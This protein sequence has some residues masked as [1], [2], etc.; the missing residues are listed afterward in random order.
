MLGTGFGLTTL[1]AR[2]N[3]LAAYAV[4]AAI[5]LLVHDYERGYISTPLGLTRASAG[6]YTDA[7][8]AI[9]TAPANE[10][11]F[12]W[13][14]GRRALLLEASTTRL[15]GGAAPAAQSVAVTA[16][17]YTVSFYGTGT[18]TLS[19][20]A[21]ATIDGLGAARK[22]HTFTPAAGTL[23]ATPSGDVT[24]VQ[25]ETGSAAMSYIP[26][27]DG[28]VARAADT[29]AP[30]DLSGYGLSGGYTVVVWGQMDAVVGVYDRVVQLDNGNNN[31]RHLAL[32][33]APL[34]LF[35]MELFAG[36]V[37]QGSYSV[38]GGPQL[39]QAFKLAMAVGENH[40]RAA[41]NGAVGPLD[42]SVTYVAP[43]A[44]R[45]AQS[46]SANKPA[47]LSLSRIAVYPGK[48]TGSQLGEITT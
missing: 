10:A 24:M 6:T 30:I 16:Q 46:I 39:G 29:V 12:D 2:R 1:A 13:S 4:G 28:A 15:I 41:R 42:A 21:T 27:A 31:N 34:N 37:S 33:A 22:T 18:V 17:A 48:L 35:A 26:G 40:F 23:T 20:A 47:R 25:L 11:R 43:T 38:A 45:L 8:G 32:W 19:G 14:T 7:A 5:P 3:R 36:N 44:L 9:Q